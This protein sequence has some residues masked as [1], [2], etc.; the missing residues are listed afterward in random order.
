MIGDHKNILKPYGG[1]RW[2][3]WWQNQTPS[4]LPPPPPSFRR[5][6]FYRLLV[7][8]FISSY[9]QCHFPFLQKN[10]RENFPTLISSIKKKKKKRKEERRRNCTTMTLRLCFGGKH[11][12]VSRIPSLTSG[13]ERGWLISFE[14]R[15]FLL[16]LGVTLQK[17][18]RPPTIYILR[19]LSSINVIYY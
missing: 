13:I 6:F 5:G 16:L 7:A 10:C 11:N 17:V 14:K 1:I 8:R 12:L 3:L 15:T 4:V 2:I 18:R 9:T 19:N